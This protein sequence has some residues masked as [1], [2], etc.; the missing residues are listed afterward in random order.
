MKNSVRMETMC[1]SRYIFN[2]FRL[3]IMTLVTL[4]NQYLFSFF[5]FRGV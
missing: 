3:Y 5:L 4:L 1:V 2:G